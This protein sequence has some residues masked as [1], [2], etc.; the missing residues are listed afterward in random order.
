MINV[1][2]KVIIIIL[3]LRVTVVVDGF[4]PKSV[5]KQPMENFENVA[6][7]LRVF[8]DSLMVCVRDLRQYLDGPIL[9][10][11]FCRGVRVLHW[12]RY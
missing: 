10:L 7:V 1:E 2:A 5:N 4:P 3:I 12:F 8:H 11:L 9:L 6:G